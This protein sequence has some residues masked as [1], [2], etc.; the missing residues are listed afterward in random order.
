[1]EQVF[2]WLNRNGPASR[3][4]VVQ[5]IGRK[6]AF[7]LDAIRNLVLEGT[8][9]ETIGPNR[10]K[11]LSVVGSRNFSEPIGTDPVPEPGNLQFPVPTTRGTGTGT[12]HAGGED[13]IPF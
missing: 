13:D 5:G 7:V 8:I 2:T 12:V 4:D 10:A 3:N 1:M 11:L 9:A 6:R